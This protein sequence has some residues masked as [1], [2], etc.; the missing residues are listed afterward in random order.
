MT[1]RVGGFAAH[2]VIRAGSDIVLDDL[3]V[4]YRRVGMPTLR[5][6]AVNNGDGA[7]GRV[8]APCPRGCVHGVGATANNK[9]RG[10]AAPRF[11]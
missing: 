2:A 9:K 8:G 3:A 4:A 10:T 5:Y 7:S 6:A 1:R 11:F